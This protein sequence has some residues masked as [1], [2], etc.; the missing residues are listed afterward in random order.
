MQNKT[1]L[2]FDMDGTITESRQDISIEMFRK[3]AKLK[4]DIIVISGAE[5]ERMKKQLSNLPVFYMAQSGNDTKFW[6][7]KLT[8]KELKEI[9]KHADKIIYIKAD[10][11][12]NRGCQVSLSLVGHNA[13]MEIK[14]KFDPDGTLRVDL[15]KEFP[16]E[17]ETLECRVAGTTCLD[18]T[19]KNGTKGKNIERLINYFKWKKE[20]CVYF[21]DKLMK[22]GNDESVVGVMDTV[23]VANPT[24]LLLKLSKY[25]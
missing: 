15:L 23:A 14:K 18:Y 2:F 3:L 7:D 16:F 22:G 13:D 19:R 8:D 17:S 24:D 6:N 21:G 9:Y 5:I 20:D 4:Q 12:Q 1:H 10:M 25:V 11:L